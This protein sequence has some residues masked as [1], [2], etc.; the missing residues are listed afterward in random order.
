MNTWS[1]VSS[2]GVVTTV[3]MGDE[4]VEGLPSVQT[5]P[6]SLALFPYDAILT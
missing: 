1:P 4:T 6:I 2:L 3:S 5:F